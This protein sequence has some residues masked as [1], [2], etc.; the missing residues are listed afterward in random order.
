MR[1]S[2]FVGSLILM[3]QAGTCGGSLPTGKGAPRLSSTPITVS[4]APPFLAEE[5]ERLRA[6][7]AQTQPG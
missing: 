5:N 2:L 1:I 6:A 4:H 3:L 7:R